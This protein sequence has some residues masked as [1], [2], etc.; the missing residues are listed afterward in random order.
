MKVIN[1]LKSR[2]VRLPV[3]SAVDLVAGS[4]VIRGT[5]AA[6]DLGTVIINAAA[7]AAGYVGILAEGHSYAKSGSALVAGAAHS[8][9]VPGANGA[10][11]FA[12]AGGNAELF[13]SRQIEL[14]EGL[15]LCRIDYSLTGVAATSSNG[16]TVTI[17]ALEN[18]IP[19][20]FLYAASGDAIGKLR[21]IDVDG[22]NGTCT[23][24]VAFGAGD[25][26]G[27][28][29][30]VKI[31]PLLH[32]LFPF[33]VG[34]TTTP[35]KIATTAGAG[36]G[37]IVQLERHIIRNGADE[38]LDPYTHGN[39]SGLNSLNQFGIY[40]VFGMASTVFSPLA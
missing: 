33:T 21:F 28:G 29:L 4:L 17:G 3:H 20:G 31:L 22:N 19:T 18:D 30:I 35:T 24:S 34:N 14:V 40:G 5:T 36:A 8:A 1:S 27:T 38:M 39:L 10:A 2:I 12:P 37:R 23:T 32:G 16:T 7:S 15:T 9:V 6:T 26:V 25:A 11:W 13:P